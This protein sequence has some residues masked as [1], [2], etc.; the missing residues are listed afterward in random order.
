[1]IKKTSF[2]SLIFLLITLSFYSQSG[3]ITG[4]VKDKSSK[5]LIFGAKIV[6]K[7]QTGIGAV[8]DL[9]GKFTIENVKSGSIILEIKYESY[10]TLTLEAFELKAVE[11]KEILIEIEKLI[12][13]FKNV[14][15]TKKVNK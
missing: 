7:G 3:R 14:T 5:E 9:D 12:K 4:V 1:M 6:V 11:S 2:L 15:V 13:D 10:K 8:T